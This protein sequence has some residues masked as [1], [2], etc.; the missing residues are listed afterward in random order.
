[1]RLVSAYLLVK[2]V[3]TNFF[4]YYYVVVYTFCVTGMI[5]FGLE[6]LIGNSLQ[7]VLVDLTSTVKS[8]FEGR[9]MF[10]DSIFTIRTNAN[11]VIYKFASLSRLS[12][13]EPLRN[14]GPYWEA[15]VN[16][17]IS[18]I[19]ILFSMMHGRSIW[20]YRNILLI[21]NII[22]TL[23]TTG[24]IACVFL[25]IVYIWDRH[26]SIKFVVYL[27]T[28]LAVFWVAYS[29]LDH[30][31]LKVTEQL[32]KTEINSSGELV[33]NQ[34]KPNRFASA[35]L[36]LY[37]FSRHP[38]LGKGTIVETRFATGAQ[39]YD[40]WTMHRNN[41]ITHYLLSYGIIIF[42]LYFGMLYTGMARASYAI[43]GTRIYGL[44]GL[45]LM[46]IIGFS[47]LYFHKPLFYA[48]AYSFFINYKLHA[49]VD[50]VS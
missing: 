27:V 8:P 34:G 7:S 16:A 13:F 23:S 18:S 21:I 10:G 22:S 40:Y 37:E 48:F 38:I 31:G 43:R 36:D 29:R 47:E 32:D 25:I 6:L 24:Y 1:M 30:L 39:G 35:L 44:Y 42:L 9:S 4:R 12:A 15:G 33:S 41:G 49:R 50:N 3:G 28:V 45:A 17:G 20:N 5:L 26:Q 2:V 14:S 46:F 19:A 11:I